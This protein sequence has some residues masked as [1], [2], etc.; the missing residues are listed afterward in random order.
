[1]RHI[2][3]AFITIAVIY[4]LAGQVLGIFMGITKDFS[5]RDLHAH[6]NLVGWASLALAGLVYRCYPGLAGRW[7]AGLHFW[8][9]NAGA[10]LLT[11]GLFILIQYDIE[12][13]V[14]LGSLLTVAGTMVFVVNIL[15]GMDEG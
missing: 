15:S 1:M 7:I 11:V 2:D 5:Q 9:A 10:L 13:P 8:V 3:R 6:I 14:I 12:F 4:L